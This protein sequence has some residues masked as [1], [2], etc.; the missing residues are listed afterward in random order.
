MVSV[1][2]TGLWALN[3]TVRHPVIVNARRGGVAFGGQMAGVVAD[4]RW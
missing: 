1:T 3:V 4:C 2:L